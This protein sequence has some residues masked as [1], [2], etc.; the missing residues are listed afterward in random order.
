MVTRDG[1]DRNYGAVGT[2]VPPRKD[3]Y[4]HEYLP[5]VDT[6]KY[7]QSTAMGSNNDMPMSTSR[8]NWW[9]RLL[10]CVGALVGLIIVTVSLRD[11]DDHHGTFHTGSTYNQYAYIV[12]GAGPSG[13]LVA[14]KLAKKLLHEGSHGRVLLLESGTASQSSVLTTL[15]HPDVSGD[16]SW[17]AK[18]L[19][20]NKYDIPLM[21][22]GVASSL[23]QQNTRGPVSM[24]HWPIA[25]ALLVRALGGCGLLNAMIYVRALPEDFARWN[26][27]TWSFENALA[28]YKDLE[29]YMNLWDQPPFWNSEDS[30]HKPWR[31]HKGPVHTSPGGPEV[32]AIA[33]LF[34]ETMLAAGWPLAGHGFNAPDASARVGAGYYEFNIRNGVRHSIA[35]AFL[36]GW[37][38]DDPP[39]TNLVIRTKATVTKVM[40]GQ[41]NGVPKALGVEYISTDTGNTFHAMLCEANGEVIMSAGA[42]MT[43]QLLANSGIR[44]GGEVADLPGVGKNLQDHPVVAMSWEISS[45]LA[46]K[47]SSIYTIAGEIEDYFSSVE[48]LKNLQGDPARNATLEELR[49]QA[50]NLGTFATAGFSSG[51]FLTSPWAVD[52]VPDIQLTVFPRV[53]EPH[54][55]LLERKNA[56]RKGIKFDESRMTEGAMLV[57]VALLQPEARYE[58]KPSAEKMDLDSDFDDS[59]EQT[60]TGERPPSIRSDYKLPSITLPADRSEYLTELDVQ[61]LAWGMDEVRNIMGHAPLIALTGEELMPGAQVT[62]YTLEQHVKLHHLPNSHWVGSAKMGKDDDPMAVVNDKLQVRGVA[63]LRVVDASIMPNIPNGNTHSTVCVIASMAADII[64]EDRTEK[65]ANSEQRTLKTNHWFTHA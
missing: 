61:R 37:N 9:M 34:I 2:E 52:G 30:A 1:N 58:V 5:A 63:G 27:T 15:Q 54:V 57:T 12:I 35:E 31:G 50:S 18:T 53:V 45:T 23:G 41:E 19:R 22:S 17:N 6:Q 24:N 65:K 59:E 48:S 46:Q 14:T 44:D 20:L 36:G 4:K 47:A 8:G 42:I 11:S 25:K 49:E 10:F 56:E 21:W 13:I 60:F 62:G 28:H 64:F 16:L 29:T 55:I 43:P 26:M 3:R 38:A 39:P 7:L 51:A 40:V 33:P 32:D